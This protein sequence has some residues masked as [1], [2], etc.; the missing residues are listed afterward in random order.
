MRHIVNYLSCK[1]VITAIAATLVLTLPAG[2]VTLHSACD[3][4]GGWLPSRPCLSDAA[5]PSGLR[6]LFPAAPAHLMGGQGP[7]R[8]GWGYAKCP[9]FAPS[10]LAQL[11]G[12]NLS[13][14][15]KLTP[16]PPAQA[17]AGSTADSLTSVRA[18]GGPADPPPATAGRMSEPARVRAEY[19]KAQLRRSW[20][21]LVAL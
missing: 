14:R 7:A 19:P 12:L 11:A 4:Y 13:L 3:P 9:R 5:R 20:G 8:I 16:F 18:S 17:A 15:F 1:I 21:A 6:L 10:C 2:V